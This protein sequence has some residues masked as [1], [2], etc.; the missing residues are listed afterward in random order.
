M[1]GVKSVGKVVYFT[2]TFPFAVLTVLVIRGVT[3]PGAWD[4]IYFYIWPNWDQLT[5]LKV[6]IIAI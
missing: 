3:L 5:N 6:K 1:K 2:A 4:G